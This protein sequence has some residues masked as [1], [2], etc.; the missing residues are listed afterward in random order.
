MKTY[1]YLEAGGSPRGTQGGSDFCDICHVCAKET[2]VAAITVEQALHAREI[3]EATG[4]SSYLPI[5]EM[6][7]LRLKEKQL[8]ICGGPEITQTSRSPTLS[9]HIQHPTPISHPKGLEKS[10]CPLF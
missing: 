5:S 4:C 6:K 9:E 3:S 1:S 7:K 8:P 10:V 2:G